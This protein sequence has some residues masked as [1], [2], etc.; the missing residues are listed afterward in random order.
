MSDLERDLELARTLLREHHASVLPDPSFAARVVA[1]LPA[2]PD[3]LRW[4]A[5]RLLPAALTLA[6]LL[7]VLVWSELPGGD[8]PSSVADVAAWM[9]DPGTGEAP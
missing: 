6:L 7:G 8:E 9:V 4:A 3:P 5:A 1:R 2:A